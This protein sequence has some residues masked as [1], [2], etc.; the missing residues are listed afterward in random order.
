MLPPNPLFIYF[1]RFLEIPKNLANFAAGEFAPS[2]ARMFAKRF[3][4]GVQG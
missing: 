1:L 3:F 4:G 2:E